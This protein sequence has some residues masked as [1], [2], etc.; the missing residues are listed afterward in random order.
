MHLPV[1]HPLNPLY[2]VLAGA[3]GAF[4]L[5]FGVLSI[6]TIS[7][8]GLFARSDATALGLQTNLAM[9]IL[10]IAVGIVALASA[11]TGGNTHHFAALWLGGAMS[12]LGMLMLAVQRTDANVLN[13]SVWTCLVWMVLGMVLVAAGLYGK[14]GSP[15]R[16]EAEERIRHRPTGAV[17]TDGDVAL[18]RIDPTS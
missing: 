14:S 18:A 12:V 9:G 11:V 5:L 3:S 15:Q 17:P 6:G 7:N 8:D 4:L 13:A 2:R 16:A 10:S 1:N